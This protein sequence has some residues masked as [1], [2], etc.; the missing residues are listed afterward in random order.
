MKGKILIG[1]GVILILL[2]IL[3]IYA[4]INS[5]KV[6]KQN[7]D[8]INS[9][10][11]E[12]FQN[13]VRIPDIPPSLRSFEKTVYTWEMITNEKEVTTV[14][15]IHDTAFDRNKNK[16]LATLEMPQG[17]D[18][19]LFVKVMPA[20]VSDAQALASSQDLEHTNLGSNE[21][22][23]YS[24]IELFTKD[25]NSNQVTKIVWEF[26]K[27]KIIESSEEFYENLYK[28]GELSLRTLYTLQRT[29]LIILSP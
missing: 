24:K 28:Y 9:K 23:G 29:A 2:I 10:L 7:T 4:I 17:Q 3:S 15:F 13:I 6:V 22:I 12:N 26:D 5:F 27:E 20:V 1:L 14:T 25:E 16:I 8:N 11:K 18:A 19:S 21:K